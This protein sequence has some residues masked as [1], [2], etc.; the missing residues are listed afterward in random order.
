MYKTTSTRSNTP[1]CQTKGGMLVQLLD[2]EALR[3]GP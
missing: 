2:G 1:G 3:V